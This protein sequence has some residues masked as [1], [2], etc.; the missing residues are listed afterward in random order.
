VS[1]LEQH[2]LNARDWV[3]Y[4]NTFPPTRKGPPAP[5][6]LPISPPICVNAQ[7]GATRWTGDRAQGLLRSCSCSR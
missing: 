5:P 7:V 3:M 6:P 4:R 1:T 2:Q